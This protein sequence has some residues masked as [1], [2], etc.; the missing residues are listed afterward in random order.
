MAFQM[1]HAD[2]RLAG[3]PRESFR[4]LQADEQGADEARRVGHGDPVTRS[5]KARESLF[6]LQSLCPRRTPPNSA[7]QNVV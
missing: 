7:L 1:M 6:K 2:Q 5:V 4:G 3:D